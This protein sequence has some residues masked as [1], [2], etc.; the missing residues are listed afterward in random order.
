MRLLV[1]DA[2]ALVDLLLRTSRASAFG[3]TL[4]HPEADLHVPALCDLEVVSAV[5]SG[6]RRDRLSVRRAEEALRDYLDLPLTRHGHQKL[7]H[8]CFQLRDVLSSYD[9]AYVAL[10]EWLEA[11]L[12]T[13]DLRLARAA[14]SLG[15]S[16]LT[17]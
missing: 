13:A 15:V 8:R 2:S 9:A 11:D 7:V 16:C 3:Q 6:F 1:V 17:A 4:T 12:V 5:R 14:E 10:A